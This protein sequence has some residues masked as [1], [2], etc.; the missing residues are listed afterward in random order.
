MSFREIVL[1]ENSIQSQGKRDRHQHGRLH[2]VLAL[3]FGSAA[4]FF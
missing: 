2:A 3:S 1:M 4:V